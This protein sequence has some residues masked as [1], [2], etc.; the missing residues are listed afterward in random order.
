MGFRKMITRRSALPYR[1]LVDVDEMTIDLKSRGRW[2]RNI[3]GRL[4]AL[5][6]SRSRKIT[7]RVLSA[8]VSSGR[9]ARIYRDTVK[10]MLD[11]DAVRPAIVF[12]LPWGV[13]V[14]SHSTVSLSRNATISVDRKWAC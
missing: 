7:L 14:L 9:I 12:S 8:V 6:L 11:G 2:V 3:N 1:R 13:P 10:R 4:R 5:R